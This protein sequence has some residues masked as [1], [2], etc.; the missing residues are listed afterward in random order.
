V[1]LEFLVEEF[2]TQECLNKILPKILFENV[3]YK[4][5][6]FRGK[7]DLI[8]KLPER[9]KGYKCWITDDY[10]I[11]ILVDRDNEDCQVLKEKL[12]NIAQQTGLITKTI[13][14]DKK[15]FQV[16]NRIAIEELEAWFFGDIQAIV[17]AYP[18]VSTNVG[19]QAKYRKPDE[20]TGGTWENLEKILQKAGYHRG[21]LEKVKAAR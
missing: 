18:K 17:S 19:Q 20:I 16:L 5:Y 11:I 3:T 7:S 4:I 10:R 8:K 12:E 13:S 14:E 15:T 1:H 9:L 2:S 6:A 21:G